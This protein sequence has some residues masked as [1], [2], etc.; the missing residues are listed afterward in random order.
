MFNMILQAKVATPFHPLLSGNAPGQNSCRFGRLTNPLMHIAIAIGLSKPVRRTTVSRSSRSRA[1]WVPSCDE[2]PLVVFRVIRE[3]PAISNALRTYQ[4][5]MDLRS[6]AQR[7]EPTA[8]AAR[9]L[10]RAALSAMRSW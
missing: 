4:L 3:S 10:L 6:R 5:S 7:V 1:T 8:R 2:L 9:R